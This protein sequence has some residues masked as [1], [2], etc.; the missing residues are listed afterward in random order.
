MIILAHKN[1]KRLEIYGRPFIG[2]VKLNTLAPMFY[3][4]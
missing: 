2:A 4:A 1:G 3:E